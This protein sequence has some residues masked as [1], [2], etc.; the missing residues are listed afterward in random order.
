MGTV[1]IVHACWMP[2]VLQNYYFSHRAEKLVK[3]K[4]LAG[5]LCD[6]CWQMASIEKMEIIILWRLLNCSAQRTI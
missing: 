5:L 6:I 4:D 3:I 1:Q 2:D